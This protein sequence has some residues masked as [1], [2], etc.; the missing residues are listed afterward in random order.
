M[1]DRTVRGSQLKW[2]L[3]VDEH[4]RERLALT[5]DRGITA[6]D[7]IDTFAELFAMPG[8]P[9]PQPPLQQQSEDSLTHTFITPGTGF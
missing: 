1:F 2:L 3:I 5:V 9:A 7:V 6:E 8:V 4:T